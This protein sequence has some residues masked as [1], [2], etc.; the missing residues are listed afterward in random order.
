[1]EVRLDEINKAALV[2]VQDIHLSLAI[3]KE[4][5]NVRLAAKLTGWRIDIRSESQLHAGDLPEF[6]ESVAPLEEPDY[7][8]EDIYDTKKIAD[9]P[10]DDDEEENDQDDEI[11]EEEVIELT[12]IIDAEVETIDDATADED[13]VVTLEDVVLEDVDDSI[14]DLSGFDDDEDED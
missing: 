13:D 10:D 3:G 9:L 5:Q 14:I 12:P 6:M 7:E 1:V 4:G 11:Y 2:I 8:E